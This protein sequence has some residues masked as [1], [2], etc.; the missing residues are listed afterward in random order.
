MTPARALRL[1]ERFLH[2]KSLLVI[3]GLLS[4]GERDR[5]NAHLDRWAKQHGLKRKG[6]P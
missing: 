1:I 3:H 6:T 2:A 4:D 5:V